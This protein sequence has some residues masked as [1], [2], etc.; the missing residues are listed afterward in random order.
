MTQPRYEHDCDRCT[1]L[2]QQGTEDVYYCQQG[3]IP[4][5][6]FRWGDDGPAYQ[7]GWHLRNELN[8]QLAERLQQVLDSR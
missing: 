8:P 6:V 7:S 4:T 2:G 3:P 1:F 5:V